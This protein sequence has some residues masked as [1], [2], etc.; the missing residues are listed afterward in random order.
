MLVRVLDFLSLYYSIFFFFLNLVAWCI[1]DNII[2]ILQNSCSRADKDNY[3]HLN[4][5]K[6]TSIKKI[7]IVILGFL[8]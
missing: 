6:Q 4:Q 5:I 8:N 2:I 7:I 1:N 3:N